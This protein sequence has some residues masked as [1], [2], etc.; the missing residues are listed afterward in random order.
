MEAFFHAVLTMIL[1][2]LAVFA[3]KIH[4]RATVSC[5]CASVQLHGSRMKPAITS[6]RCFPQSPALLLV[7]EPLLSGLVF[8]VP[9]VPNF[10]ILTVRLFSP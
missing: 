7:S 8:P 6:F 10:A 5:V 2:E 9:G 1:L 3:A 4:K